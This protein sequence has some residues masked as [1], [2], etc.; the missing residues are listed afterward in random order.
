MGYN[1]N[2]KNFKKNIR[3]LKRSSLDEKSFKQLKNI[4][5]KRFK[6]V[7]VGAVAKIEDSYGF[8]WGEDDEIEEEDMSKEQLKM[9]YLFLD[10]RE[11]IFDQGNSEL[12]RFLEEMKS[13]NI[14]KIYNEYRFIKK[15]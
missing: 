4:I 2:R 7:F 6:T 11:K 8:L 1:S 9:Y 5:N 14:T 12:N 10:L 15:D 13:Y 3:D